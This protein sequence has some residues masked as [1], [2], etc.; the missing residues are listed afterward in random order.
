MRVYS[1]PSDFIHIGF[2]CF[3]GV[4]IYICFEPDIL[5]TGEA[6]DGWLVGGIKKK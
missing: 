2:H 5:M 4:P 3:I 1:I 6:A